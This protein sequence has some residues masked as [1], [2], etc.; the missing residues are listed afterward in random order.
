MAF[1]H[2]NRKG[3]TYFLHEKLVRLQ[4]N[5]REQRI[6]FFSLQQKE[7]ALDA[8]PDGW[9]VVE[10]ATS[11]MPVLKKNSI[12]PEAPADDEDEDA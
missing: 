4:G 10:T 11:G 5:N 7:G 8:V 3:Q 9:H 12:A 6:Y 2:T 1:A